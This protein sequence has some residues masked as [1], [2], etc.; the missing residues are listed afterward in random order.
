[1]HPG[2]E[3]DPV[4]GILVLSSETGQGRWTFA[5]TGAGGRW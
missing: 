4:T 2:L 5:W 1:V 3:R